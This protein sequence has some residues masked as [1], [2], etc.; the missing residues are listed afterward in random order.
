M[1]VSKLSP[2]SQFMV[3]SLLFFWDVYY[4]QKAVCIIS[5]IFNTGVLKQTA[6]A[7][8]SQNRAWQIP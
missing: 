4:M 3:P 5:I 1:C 8:F 2:A 7:K 6:P